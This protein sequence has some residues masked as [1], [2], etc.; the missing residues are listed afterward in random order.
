MSS[1]L[2]KK[3]FYIDISNIKLE[4]VEVYVKAQIEKLKG[5]KEEIL[6]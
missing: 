1:E 3:V 4:H 2:T 5:M 6:S